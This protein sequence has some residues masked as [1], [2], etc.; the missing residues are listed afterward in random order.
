M[1]EVRKDGRYFVNESIRMLDDICSDPDRIQAAYNGSNIDELFNRIDSLKMWLG[2]CTYNVWLRTKDC[3]PLAEKVYE[4][5]SQIENKTVDEKTDELACLA[6]TA[7]KDLVNELS[8]HT[9]VV[10]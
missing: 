6:E 2:K 9:A 10:T 4:A 3:S 7:V 1:A 8:K 5:I